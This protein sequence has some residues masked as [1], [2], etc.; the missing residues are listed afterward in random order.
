[1]STRLPLLILNIK[2][3]KNNIKSKKTIKKRQ[4]MTDVLLSLFVM[5]VIFLKMKNMS[6]L[7]VQS[8]YIDIFLIDFFIIYFI[9][10]ATRQ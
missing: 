8:V 1:M 4:D 10:S 9:L 2:T 3:D 7:L 6:S 5:Y